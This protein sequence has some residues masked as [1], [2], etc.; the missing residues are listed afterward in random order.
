ME[1]SAETQKILDQQNL[2][3]LNE[4]ID[5]IAAEKQTI[6]EANDRL[7]GICEDAKFLLK[8]RVAIEEDLT[9]ALCY[10]TSA[11]AML[12]TSM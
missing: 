6:I 5:A 1:P 2:D 3:T 7:L 10:L 4:F 11:H 9:A 8:D 12:K